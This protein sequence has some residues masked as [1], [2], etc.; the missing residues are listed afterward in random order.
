MSRKRIPWTLTGPL[1]LVTSLV[2]AAP[3]QEQF[4]TPNGVLVTFAGADSRI[5]KSKYVRITT[6]EDF[7]IL[8]M[9]HLGKDPKEYDAYYNPHGVPTIDFDRCM[10][11]AVFQGRTWNVA[12]VYVK[13]IDERDG[14]VV[15]RFDDRSYQTSG[16]D[17]GGG[18][19]SAT[20]YGI[21]V[22]PRSDRPVILEENVQRYIGGEPEWKERARFEAVKP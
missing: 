5:D 7:Q 8:Y 17:S 18:A 16:S 4:A 13:T 15:V 3:T 22:L 1:M 6:A 21:F 9:R 12:G 20:P 11:I 2:T 19:R 14:H 10:V